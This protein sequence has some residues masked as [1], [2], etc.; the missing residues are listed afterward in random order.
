[1][2]VLIEAISVVI[3][4]D[5]LLNAFNDEWKEFVAIVPNQTLCADTELARVGFMTPNDVELFIKKLEMFGLTYLENDKCVDIAVVDQLRGPT[6]ECDWLEFSHGDLSEQGHR[7]AGCSLLNSEITKLFTP[8]G[9]EHENSLSCSYG[10]VPTEHIE[11]GL[12]FLRH[13]DGNDVYLNPTTGEEV[14]VGRTGKT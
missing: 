5:S 10:F 4:A 7:V 8:D 9:W 13:E 6:M 14:Y 2:A 3:R 11:K 12:K 1:M